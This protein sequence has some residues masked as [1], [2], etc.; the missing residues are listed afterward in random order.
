MVH[1]KCSFHTTEITGSENRIHLCVTWEK[2]REAGLKVRTELSS[3]RKGPGPG[4][5]SLTRYLRNNIV[6]RDPIKREGVGVP[7]WLS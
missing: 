2:R 4:T 3:G 1:L 7:G 5:V 6:K